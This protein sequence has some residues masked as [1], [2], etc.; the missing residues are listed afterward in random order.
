MAIALDDAYQKLAE[1]ATEAQRQTAQSLDR[2]HAELT[3]IRTR[4]RE[5][6]RVLKEVG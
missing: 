5:L 1:K 4:L 6:E 3:D 2:A